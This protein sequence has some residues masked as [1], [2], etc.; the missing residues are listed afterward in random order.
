G[1]VPMPANDSFECSPANVF[2]VSLALSNGMLT[3]F[4]MRRDP[5]LLEQREAHASAHCQNAFEA[6]TGDDA[7][8]LDAG[9]IKHAYRLA[10]LLGQDRTQPEAVPVLGSEIRRRQ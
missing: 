5:T 6:S 1:F 2:V 9:V 8:T 7:E 4:Q 3:E 10:Q